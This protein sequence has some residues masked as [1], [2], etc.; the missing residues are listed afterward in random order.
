MSL[1]LANNKGRVGDRRYGTALNVDCTTHRPKVWPPG[2]PK[3]K[4]GLVIELEQGKWDNLTRMSEG[5]QSG[6][7]G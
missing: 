3:A 1:G 2:E 7:W 5:I 6:S 4:Q